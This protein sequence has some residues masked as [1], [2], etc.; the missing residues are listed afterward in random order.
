MANALTNLQRLASEL[1]FTG[2][3][4]FEDLSSTPADA[5]RD[6]H[7][8]R[9]RDRSAHLRSAYFIGR[10][11]VAYFAS[12]SSGG[13]EAV[14]EVQNLVWNDDSAP[15][16]FVAT[17]NDLRVYDAWAPPPTVDQHPTANDPRR[18]ALLEASANFLTHLKA[19]SRPQIDSGQYRLTYEQHFQT[20][21]RC[22]E[23]LLQNLLTLHDHLSDSLDTRFALRLV[24]RSILILQLEHRKMIDADAYS[25]FLPGVESFVDLLD[26]HDATYDLFDGLDAE[27]NGDLLRPIEQEREEVTPQDLARLARFLKGQES[28]TTGQSALWPLYDFAVIPISLLSS[29]YQELLHHI[30]PQEASSKGVYYTPP[31]LVDAVLDEV[32]PWPGNGAT[33]AK[34]LPTIIDPA[35]G[36]GVFLVEAFRRLV[37]HAQRTNTLVGPALCR[38][39][40]TKHIFGVDHSDEAVDVTAF[41]LDIAFLDVVAS[42]GDKPPRF[43]ALRLPRGHNLRVEDALDKGFR[44]SFDLVVG[45]PPW[46]RVGRVEAERW[47][48]ER[49]GQIPMQQAAAF[50]KLAE[51]L[52]PHGRVALVLPA[53]WMFNQEEPDQEFR[54]SLFGKHNVTFVANLAAFAGGKARLFKGARS[55]A[56]IVVYEPNRQNTDEPLRYWAPL[57]S[58]AAVPL[59][60]DPHGEWLVAKSDLLSFE[61]PLILKSL[62]SGGPRH[63]QLMRRLF[64]SGQSLQDTIRHFGIESARGL[65]AA[66]AEEGEE[67]VP[68]I[69]KQ[70]PAEWKGRLNV[71]SGELQDA[72][73][74]TLKHSPDRRFFEGPRVVVKKGVTGGRPVA[75]FVEEAA[76]FTDNF[77][78]I[79][80][81]AQDALFLKA[82]A[83]YL[84]SAVVGYLAIVAGSTWGIDRRTINKKELLQFPSR[85]LTDPHTL[86]RLAAVVDRYEG[87]ATGEQLS[88]IDDTVAEAFGLS[89]TERALISD[90]LDTRHD[91]L[92]G[93]MPVRAKASAVRS[94]VSALKS[95]LQPLLRHTRQRLDC[96]VFVHDA[97]P[98]G[99]IEVNLIEGSGR[100]RTHV[101]ASSRALTDALASLDAVLVQSRGSSIYSRRRYMTFSGST[102]QIAKSMDAELWTTTCALDDADHLMATLIRTADAH[103]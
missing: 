78:A 34:T 85:P 96:D 50:A 69:N 52:A 59:A 86:V 68:G 64:A 31:V 72:P 36:S 8:S 79:A 63:T 48:L 24:L 83:A 71:L 82:L 6:S 40:L 76:W 54:R 89:A 98:M 67:I 46:K 21:K 97:S 33:I 60:R 19:L 61:A 29:I 91:R 23:S 41:G 70:L 55:P 20:R 66:F 2:S 5:G 16:L 22:Q 90:V 53:K 88:I 18:I 47:P 65:Q 17:D 57:P 7:L 42:E 73:V 37:A 49:W 56:S 80:G 27:L 75:A 43:P 99:L 77:T 94:Y 81:H 28:L 39:L 44:Q 101:R 51:E 12:V 87:A 74:G 95:V 25:M 58:L 100:G 1:G 26:S 45:N 15:I 38:D 10:D 9:L 13:H 32:L 35:C 102:M 84:N 14:A 3:S 103:E 30:D 4:G 92:L 11:P 62:F 93:E